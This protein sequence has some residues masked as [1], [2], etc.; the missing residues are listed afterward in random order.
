MKYLITLILVTTSLSVGS[1][2]YPAF[3]YSPE[4]LELSI[5]QRIELV[6]LDS[7]YSNAMISIILFGMR[8]P[9]KR[10][11]TS[12]GPLARAEKRNGYAS[13]NSIEDSVRDLILYHRHF[14]VPESNLSEY[15]TYLKRKRY[16]ECSEELYRKSLESLI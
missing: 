8:H 9:H 14:K 13:Y 4:K 11:T 10:P 5:D 1:A 12:L 3:L 7:G 15:V 2:T 16:Y 6:L